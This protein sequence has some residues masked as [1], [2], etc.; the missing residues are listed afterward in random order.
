MKVK[1]KDGQCNRADIIAIPGMLRLDK[2]R[3]TDESI[4]SRDA[5]LITRHAK[6]H[7]ALT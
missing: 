4:I 7:G 6:M 5:K 2:P 1:V 3:P